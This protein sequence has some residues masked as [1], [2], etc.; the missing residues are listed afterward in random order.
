[1]RFDWWEVRRRVGSFHLMIARAPPEFVTNEA[2]EVVDT[3]HRSDVHY[4]SNTWGAAAT[5]FGVVK[6]ADYFPV[7]NGRLQTHYTNPDRDVLARKT[8]SNLSSIHRSG[9]LGRYRFKLCVQA[10]SPYLAL[11]QLLTHTLFIPQS[12]ALCYSLGCR[13]NSETQ[14]AHI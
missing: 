2:S 8:D 6:D 7:S 12:Y 9:D 14:P 5:E 11:V 10:L 3:G 1:M 4:S 13:F